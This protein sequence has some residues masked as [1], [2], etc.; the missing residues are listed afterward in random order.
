MAIISF[1][2]KSNKLTDLEIYN[3]VISG[4]TGVMS[5]FYR[6]QRIPF[7][8]SIV[9]VYG[10]SY[11]GKVITV[12]DIYSISFTRL[13]DMFQRKSFAIDGEKILYKKRGAEDYSPLSGSIA[14]FLNSIGKNVYKEIIRDEA[15]IIESDIEKLEGDDSQDNVEECNS[16]RDN[17]DITTPKGDVID[18]SEEIASAKI[19]NTKAKSVLEILM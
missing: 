18:D 5:R 3:G 6:E 17:D 8:Q 15:P 4:N 12:D 7:E 16:S 13:L 9:S 14:N 2:G 19:K 11:I 10:T 1:K